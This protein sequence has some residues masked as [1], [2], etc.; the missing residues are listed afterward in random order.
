MKLAPRDAARFFA[1]PDTRRAGILIYGSDA[2]RVALKRQ[3]VIAALIGPEGEAEMRLTRMDGAEVRREPASLQDA[4]KAVGF[5]SGQ[6]AVL[7]EEASDGVAAVCMAALDAFRDGD[8]MIVVTA[9]SLGPRSK[10]RVAFEKHANALAAAIYDDPMG[11]DEI[12][13]ELRRVGM[14]EIGRDAMGELETLARSLEPGDFRQTLEKVS[15]YKHSDPAPLSSDD[16]LALAPATIDA[17]LDDLLHAVADGN[18]ADVVALLRRLH[19][20]GTQPLALILGAER[21]FKTLHGAACDPSGP[22][23]GIASA[24]PPVLWKMRDRMARQARRW[25]RD[26]L[27]HAVSLLLETDLALRSAAQVAPQEAVIERV[28]IRLATVAKSQLQR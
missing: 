17:A 6:R 9:G 14:G 25:G 11:R 15:L 28:F 26:R 16:V 23:K 10:L 2:M 18:V 20:Q 13:A 5:F 4:Q 12:E 24:R 19:G 27:E 1:K 8:A 22:E 7:V 21:H 3:D